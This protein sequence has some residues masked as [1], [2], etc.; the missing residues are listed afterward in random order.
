MSTG[1][2]TMPEQGRVGLGGLAPID[3]AWQAPDPN[4]ELQVFVLVYP[5]PTTPGSGPHDVHWGLAWEVAKDAWRHVELETHN[6]LQAPPPQPRYVYWGAR[7]KM[8]A[9]ATADARKILVGSMS[10]A[11]RLE[12]ESLARTIPVVEP[13]GHWNCQHWLVALIGEMLRVKLIDQRT[14][15]SVIAQTSYTSKSYFRH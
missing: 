15:D 14:W 10:L 9:Q 3:N 4:V 11:K 2:R 13:N 6:D 1:L 12:I 7:T 8:G 5:P